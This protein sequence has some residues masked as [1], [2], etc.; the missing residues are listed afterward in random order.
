MDKSTYDKQRRALMELLQHAIE[1]CGVHSDVAN[2]VRRAL[3][4]LE[5]AYEG[6]VSNPPLRTAALVTSAPPTRE[7]TMFDEKWK[8][9]AIQ[10]HAERIGVKVRFLHWMT[11]PMIANTLLNRRVTT[12]APDVIYSRLIQ[13]AKANAFEHEY[14]AGKRLRWWGVYESARD[15]Y[16]KAWPRQSRRHEEG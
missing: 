12:D 10:R 1:V 13:G 15:W 9:K 16:R 2:A 3:L 14:R 5:H 11:F 7:D 8:Q 4:E 6:R